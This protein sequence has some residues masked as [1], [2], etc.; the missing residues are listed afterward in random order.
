MAQNEEGDRQAED[1]LK[2]FTKRHAQRS[3]LVKRAQDQAD[4]HQDRAVEKQAANRVEPDEAEPFSCPFGGVD[5]NERKGMIEKMRKDK[6]K[7]NQAG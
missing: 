2:R 3:A 4:M 1:D 7:Y 5:G 6:G